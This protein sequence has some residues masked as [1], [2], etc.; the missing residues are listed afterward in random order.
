MKKLSLVILAGVLMF[1]ACKKEEVKNEGNFIKT[2]WEKEKLSNVWIPSKEIVYIDSFSFKPYT[3]INTRQII[4]EI[5]E[6]ENDK[7]P[8]PPVF[9]GQLF[10][11]YSTGKKICDLSGEEC[12]NYEINGKLE[13]VVRPCLNKSFNIK[14][15]KQWKLINKNFIANGLNCE[16]YENVI[17]KQR[18]YV[19]SEKNKNIDYNHKLAYCGN[20]RYDCYGTGTECTT[21]T[22][23]DK[24]Y[25]LVN[26]NPN[27]IQE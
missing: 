15:N 1:T 3:N 21:F 27:N 7:R 11:D 22:Y 23:G 24:T 13:I 6:S 26:P 25:I 16:E 9:D 8:D 10:T 19:P 5:I 2:S 4:F 14:N 12:S 17:S 18:L 20:N